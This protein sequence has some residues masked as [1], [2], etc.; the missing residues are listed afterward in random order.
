MLEV[1]VALGWWSSHTCNTTAVVKRHISDWLTDWQLMTE[2][3]IMWLAISDDWQHRI[4]HYVIC[5]GLRDAHTSGQSATFP[6]DS[7]LREWGP[8]VRLHLVYTVEIYV[9]CRTFHTQVVLVYLEWFRRNSLLKCVSQHEI[10]K[11]L[12]K[13]LFLRFKVVQGHRCWYH[14]KAHQQCLLSTASLCLSA[15]V[16]TL[17]EPIVAK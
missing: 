11:N 9:Q 8:L 14:R 3:R 12:L 16:L 4:M 5:Q 2:S 6:I 7:A 10:A 17:D 13:P 15:T 1:C